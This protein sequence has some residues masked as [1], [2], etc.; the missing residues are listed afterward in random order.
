[1]LQNGQL[2]IPRT[3]FRRVSGGEV[4]GEGYE[5]VIEPNDSTVGVQAMHE[6]KQYAVPLTL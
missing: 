4:F 6:C 3:W 2:V 5:V 1:M